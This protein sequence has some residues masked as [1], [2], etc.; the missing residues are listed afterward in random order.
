MLLESGQVPAPRTEPEKSGHGKTKMRKTLKTSAEFTGVGL[1]GGH[2]VKMTVS[3]AA[4]GTGVVFVRV[5][6][7]PGQQ[8]IPAR[9]DLVTDTRLCTRLT[10]EYGVSVGTV[11]HVMAAVAGFLLPAI[12]SWTGRRGYAGAP[13]LLLVLPLLILHVCHLPPAAPKPSCYH[14]DDS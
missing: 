3:P 5:D 14:F 12:P 11:E 1:H 8:T 7:E 2:P 10:N 13:L 4:S 6:A 9:Y